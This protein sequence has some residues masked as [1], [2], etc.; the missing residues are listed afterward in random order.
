VARHR[1]SGT[2]ASRSPAPV[3]GNQP[4]Q[5]G[6]AGSTGSAGSAGGAA[7]AAAR[8]SRARRLALP[9]AAVLATG[10]LF[11]LASPATGVSLAVWFALVP[12]GL[13]LCHVRRRRDALLVGLGLGA[14]ATTALSWWIVGA[15]EEY[16]G[17]GPALGWPLF[18]VYALVGQAQLPLWALVRWWLRDRHDPFA[19]TALALAYAGLDWLVPKL[20]QD[21]LAVACFADARLI[22]VVDLGGPFLLTFV[23]ALVS[24]AIVAGIVRRREAWPALAV[25]A[26]A[27]VL[28]LG[29]GQLRRGAIADITGVAP[30]IRA[31]IAQ[32][33]IGNV[34]K[35]ASE[36][37]NRTTV[38]DVLRRYGELS[39]REV[40]PRKPDL[41][42]WPETAYP[43]AW[44]ARRSTEDEEVEQELK[45]YARE[46]NIAMVFGGYHREGDREFN[47]AIAL[48]TDGS[49]SVYHKYVLV[50]FAETYPFPASLVRAPLFGSGGTPRTLDLALPGPEPGAPP[51]APVRIAPIICYEALMPSHVI[52]GVRG[53]ARAIVN[54]TN[55]AWFLSTAEKRMHLAASVLRSVE[56]RRAQL[57][58]TNTGITAMILPHGE[59]VSPGPIDA[60]AVLA[61]ELP[62][63]DAASPAVTLGAWAGPAAALGALAMLGALA[64]RR[65]RAARG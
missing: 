53:G 23:I 8:R 17:I 64:W 6:P 39:D 34:E 49:S 38:M 54:L 12:G 2:R 7:A 47:S 37:G 24:Q 42:V 40:V 43:L 1:P 5:D 13:A 52:A 45:T 16:H 63:I 27:L 35:L 31:V 56:T 3:R 21:T 25:A 4:D 57:R 9:A 61:Y 51:R 50:P 20:F 44:G 36:R 11:L 59:I 28:V 15:A 10:V 55:D 19:V 26:A 32:A 18:A 29:Y 33:N 62:L 30:R 60:E 48:A 41:L 22:Q 65:R 46:R 58:A 14:A